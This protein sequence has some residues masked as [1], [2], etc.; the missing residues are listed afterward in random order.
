MKALQLIVPSEEELSF[1]NFLNEIFGGQNQV[2]LT[3]EL[4]N[5]LVESGQWNKEELEIM[6]EEGGRYSTTR[7]TVIFP[8]Q[9][10]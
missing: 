3:D 9:V 6:K 5:E 1:L 10:G 4:I 8:P 2:D 7:G